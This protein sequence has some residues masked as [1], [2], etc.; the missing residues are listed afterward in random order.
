MAH[1]RHEVPCPWCEEKERKANED[2]DPDTDAE[3]KWER[4]AEERG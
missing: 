4:D 3:L 1:F 2:G